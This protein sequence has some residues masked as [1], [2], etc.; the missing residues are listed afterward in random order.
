MD[1]KINE[2]PEFPVGTLVYYGPD[3]QTV[4]KIAAGIVVKEGDIPITRAWYGDNVTT[5]PVVLGEL[6]RFFKEHGVQR[7]V[8]TSGVC[9]CSH[10]EGVDYPPGEECP[11]CPFWGKEKGGRQ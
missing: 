1:D 5:N 8:M 10:E 6:G 7:V 4:T 11:Y 2:Q 9:G 3:D